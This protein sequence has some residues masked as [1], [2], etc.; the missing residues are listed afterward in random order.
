VLKAYKYRIYPTI[1]QEILMEKHFGC[2]RLMYNIGLQYR[3]YAWQG[4]VSVGYNKCSEELKILKKEYPFLAE[5]NSQSLQKAL[6]D[7]DNAYSKF[8]KKEA[9]YPNFKSKDKKNSFHCPQNVVISLY[10]GKLFL[11]KFKESI[12]VKVHR[13]FKGEVR[14]CTVSKNPSGKYFVSI[15][16]ENNQSFTLKKPVLEETTVGGDL[17]I[18]TFIALSDGTKIDNP[19]FLK[20]SIEKVKY[21][22]KKLSKT[23]PKSN[24]RKK[25]KKRLAKAHEKVANQRKN[26][27][28]QGSNKITNCNDTVCLEG[29]QVKNMVKNR[30]LSSEISD[31][32]WGMF[33]EFTKYKCLHK[34]KNFIE[35]GTFEPSS[36]T[37]NCCDYVNHN[38]KLSDRTWTCPNCHAVLDRDDNAAIMVKKIG[39]EMHRRKEL[40]HQDGEVSPLSAR[41]KAGK[42]IVETSKIQDVVSE[43]PPQSNFEAT[44]PLG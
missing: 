43:N 42:R 28:H 13:K 2:V 3:Q 32:G 19:K 35:I 22:G 39:L 6:K 21:L 5:V 33:K 17:G 10:K 7:L 15:L 27:L 37:C 18:K 40:S 36:K 38:L 29:L 34:G 8:F 9:G 24:R 26:F 16:V 20:K 44:I 4:G 23:K 25:A 12:Q 11:P 30:K 14:S 41:K 31:A 1:E